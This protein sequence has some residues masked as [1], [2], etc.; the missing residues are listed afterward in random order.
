MHVIGSLEFLGIDNACDWLHDGRTAHARGVT[1]LIRFLL[2]RLLPLMLSRPPPP[3]PMKPNTPTSFTV[4][5]LTP[6]SPTS[7]AGP[8]PSFFCCPTTAPCAPSLRLSR[9][10]RTPPSRMTILSIAFTQFWSLAGSSSG[11]GSS[12]PRDVLFT[13]ATLLPISQNL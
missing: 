8:P 7:T 12:P 2:S 1:I 13:S 3:P 5:T 6:V 4:S 9:P 11:S 10:L